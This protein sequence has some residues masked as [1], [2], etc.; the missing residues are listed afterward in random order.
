LPGSKLQLFVFA[1][2][3]STTV[4]PINLHQSLL[5][6]LFCVLAEKKLREKQLF[7]LE[8]GTLF[9]TVV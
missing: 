8:T 4:T 5:V 7:E 9:S 6:A 2:S 1:R 3:T